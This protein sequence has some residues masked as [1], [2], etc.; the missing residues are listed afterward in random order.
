MPKRRWGRGLHRS[1]RSMPWSSPHFSTELS[2]HNTSY[3]NMRSRNVESAVG[4][5]SPIHAPL[6]GSLPTVLNLSRI[7]SQDSNSLASHPALLP[8]RTLTCAGLPIAVRSV[9]RARLGVFGNPV[10]PQREPEIV[11]ELSCLAALGQLRRLGASRPGGGFAPWAGS[12]AKTWS[13]TQKGLERSAEGLSHALPGMRGPGGHDLVRRHFSRD[14]RATAWRTPALKP[15]RDRPCTT[16]RF[17]RLR[18]DHAS[19]VAWLRTRLSNRSA[20]ISAA[21]S[22]RGLAGRPATIASPDQ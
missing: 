15:A 9:G 2:L 4:L 21:R 18:S 19:Q 3:A 22:F 13:A 11:S 1:D 16:A 20:A 12:V 8:V 6:H 10:P 7:A 17:Q 14:P 5:L